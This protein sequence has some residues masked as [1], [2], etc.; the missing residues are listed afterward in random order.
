MVQQH[1]HG[2]WRLGCMRP[3]HP[4]LRVKLRRAHVLKTRQI[5]RNLVVE[6]KQPQ[7][8]RTEHGGAGQG[9]R[10]GGDPHEVAFTERPAGGDVRQSQGVPAHDFAVNADRVGRARHLARGNA[11]FHDSVKRFQRVHCVGPS[12]ARHLRKSIRMMRP[13]PLAFGHHGEY[14]GVSSR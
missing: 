7:L 3:R 11:L 14:H 10:H 6:A 1:P 4:L 8:S 12:V 2:D 9:L 13:D 5:A